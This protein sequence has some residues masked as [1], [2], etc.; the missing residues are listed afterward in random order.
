M[1]PDRSTLLIVLLKFIYSPGGC[2]LAY[3]D[4]YL[5]KGNSLFFLFNVILFMLAA[6]KEDAMSKFFT[7]ENR[8]HLQKGLKDSL[9]IKANSSIP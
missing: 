5:F 6:D 4:C 3:K 7:Y 9:S 2:I 8:L 1:Q